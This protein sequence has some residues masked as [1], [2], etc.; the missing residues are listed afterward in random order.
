MYM[1]S[2]LGKRRTNERDYKRENKT[3]TNGC[4]NSKVA[5][6]HEPL[7]YE[8]VTIEEL[9]ANMIPYN[10]LVASWDLFLVPLTRGN[11]T[12]PLRSTPLCRLDWPLPETN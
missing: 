6:N 12:H 9:K 11:G 2:A 8:Q 7:S 3:M 10:T 4:K 1:H 5:K